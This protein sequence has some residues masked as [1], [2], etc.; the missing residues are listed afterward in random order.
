MMKKPRIVSMVTKAD[1][2]SNVDIELL[3]NILPSSLYEPEQ[4]PGLFIKYKSPPLT[5]I[6]FFSGKIMGYGGQ[7]LNYV[8]KMFKKIITICK[9]NDMIFPNITYPEIVMMV[10]T[11][12]V[13]RRINLEMIVE[14]ELNIMYEPEMFPGLIW[15]FEKSLVAILFSSGKINITGAKTYDE[16]EYAYKKICDLISVV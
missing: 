13:E 8:E 4:F 14:T 10:A 2:N 3:A 11:V 1:L 16:I 9:K 6:I 5:F 7:D 15:R 12:D